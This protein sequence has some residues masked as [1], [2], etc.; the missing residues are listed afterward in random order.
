MIA[1]AAFS[2]ISTE[3]A[4]VFPE[5]TCGMIEASATRKPLRP[6]TSAYPYCLF[7]TQIGEVEDL[8]SDVKGFGLEIGKH[9][10]LEPWRPAAFVI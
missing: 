3:G 9:P 7:R 2:P 1:A 4:L 6:R 5:I 8:S 10:A